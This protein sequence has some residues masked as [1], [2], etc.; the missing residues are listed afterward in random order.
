MMVQL[1]DAAVAA[2]ATAAAVVSRL[3]GLDVEG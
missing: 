2:A 3:H 1:P